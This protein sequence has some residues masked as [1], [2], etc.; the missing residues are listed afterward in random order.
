MPRQSGSPLGCVIRQNPASLDCFWATLFMHSCRFPTQTSRALF[1]LFL[2]NCANTCISLPFCLFVLSVSLYLL[3]SASIFAHTLPQ[4]E[5]GIKA[6]RKSYHTL[7]PSF[8]LL[9][10]PYRSFTVLPGFEALRTTGRNL[11]AGSTVSI[12]YVLTS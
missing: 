11:V 5:T 9:S 7:I 1:F 10:H 6:D 2:H 8:V 12:L 4:A 3:L